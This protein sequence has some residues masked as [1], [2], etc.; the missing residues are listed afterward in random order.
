MH[1]L[2]R[3]A[4]RPS[5]EGYYH[6]PRFD[7]ELL[8]RLRRRADRHHRLPVR[9]GQTWLRVGDYDKARAGGGRVPR[10][11]RAGQLLLELMD[12][13]LDDRAPGPRRPAAARQGPRPAAARH[14]RPA[15]HPRGGRRRARGAAVRAD[16][17]DDGRP[18]AVQVRRPTTST[19]SP[20]PRCAQLLAA[21]CP[22]RATTP[23]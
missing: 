12:H 1:N 22:R 17:Q 21:S 3:L 6:K 18:E 16:R 9:R 2:F 14:Q 13:G 15:L 23:C 19:S 8:A 11:L 20:R 5:L 10:H 4:S 7:R